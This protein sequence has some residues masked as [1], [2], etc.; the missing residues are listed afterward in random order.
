MKKLLILFAVAG[1]CGLFWAPAV[2]NCSCPTGSSTGQCPPISSTN[3]SDG[4]IVRHPVP[5]IRGTL[6]DTALTSVTVVNTS[7]DRK[8]RQIG[9]LAHK[10][11]FKALTELV[12]GVNKLVIRAGGHEFPLTLYYRPQT[13]PY[14]VRVFYLTDSTGNTEYQ[15]P[16][17]NDSQDYRG[18]LDT[19][20]K[21]MQTFTAERMNDLGFGRVTFNLEFEKDGRV[22]VHTLKAEHKAEHYQK[23]DGLQ[24]WSYSGRLVSRRMPHPRT[25]NLVVPAFTRFDPNT[26]RVYAHTALGGGTLALFGGGNLFTWP[27]SLADAQK[28]FMDTRMID[29]DKFFSDSVGRHTF[30]AAASTTIGAALHELGH[31]LGL[32]HSNQR[33]DIMTRGFDRFNRVFTLVEPPHAHSKE[34]YEFK[35]DDTACWAPPS[36]AWLKFSRWFAIDAKNFEEENRTLITM[37]RDSRKIRVESVHGIGAI[38][39]AAEGTSRAIAPIDYGGPAPQTVE[40]STADYGRYLSGSLAVIRVMDTQGLA[41]V[42][43]VRELMPWSFVRSWRFASITT[44]WNDP[45]RFVPMNAERLEAVAASAASAGI[46][47]SETTYVDFLPQFATEQREDIVGYAVRSFTSDKPRNIRIFTG[48]DDALRVWLNGRLV[49]EVLT[50]RPAAIDSE[51][52]TTRLAKG[53]NTLIAEVSQRGGGWGLY[54]RMEDTKG[55]DLLLTEDDKVAEL[56]MFSQH[57]TAR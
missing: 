40:F 46:S 54:L 19:A 55:S 6:T 27:D 22:K 30:W 15:S 52:G 13:N 18:K 4:A 7:S 39:L 24:L 43:S 14:V 28:A 8:S 48:S 42:V 50:L 51:S 29:K 45:E 56:G 26:G 21:L 41:K 20:M 35:E 53:K 47:K 44:P 12:P 9:G 11:S 16:V 38:V 31:T 25:K 32:P 33:H 2:G 23:M 34:Q 36:A 37:D 5:L 1:W 10:G 57:E 3:Y 49:T 17:E